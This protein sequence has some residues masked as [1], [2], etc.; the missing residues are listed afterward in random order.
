MD[1]YSLQNAYGLRSSDDVAEFYGG[2]ARDYEDELA[3]NGYATPLRCATALADRVEDPGRPI[4]DLGCGTGLSGLAL[5]DAGFTTIDGCDLSEEMLA[6][7][8]EKDVYRELV[9][10]DL[11]AALPMPA[12]AY[13]HAA[14]VGCLSPEYMPVTVLDDILGA[15]APRGCLVF[16]LNDHAA[17]DGT[18]RGRICE[19][20]DA[21]AAELLHRS[22]GE[23]LPGIGLASTVFVLRR[24]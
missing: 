8:R 6:R 15:L 17:A 4:I 24:R 11:A 10:A 23:H 22:Y 5:R 16:S 19:L 21:G 9:A 12:G 2:W 1:R 3:E 14:A 13:A 18:M 7:A 20:C